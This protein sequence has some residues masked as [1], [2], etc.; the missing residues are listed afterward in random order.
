MHQS[1]HNRV[2][3]QEDFG[4]HL[5]AC[6]SQSTQN[7]VHIQYSGR[8]RERER[9]RERESKS[10]RE[11]ERERVRESESERERERER[12]RESSVALAWVRP[13]AWLTQRSGK[14]LKSAGR[15]Q[16]T[17]PAEGC[18]VDVGAGT[19]HIEWAPFSGWAR[20]V[21]V[22]RTLAPMAILD[23]KVV[24]RSLHGSCVARHVALSTAVINF[25]PIKT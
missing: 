25:H 17:P 23:R 8:L 4:L 19:E 20:G 16:I 15:L 9:E 2:H 14:V 12:E 10:K 21:I 18:V 3:I 7:P 22:G 1:K 24:M 6:I 5:Q 13:A 11:R